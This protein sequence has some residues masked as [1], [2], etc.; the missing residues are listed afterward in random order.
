MRLTHES[1]NELVAFKALV[2]P[3]FAFHILIDGDHVGSEVKRPEFMVESLKGNQA[4]L[5]QVENLK[6]GQLAEI[7]EPCDDGL[8]LDLQF[9]HF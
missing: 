5:E 7:C 3:H 6:E 8:C 9:Q 2:D 1:F 4:L